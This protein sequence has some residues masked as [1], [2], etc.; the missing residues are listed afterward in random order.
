MFTVYKKLITPETSPVLGPAITPR[1]SPSLMPTDVNVNSPAATALNPAT[2]NLTAAMAME[3]FSLCNYCCSP[4]NKTK[5]D[6]SNVDA[7]LESL[8]HPHVIQDQIKPEFEFG[9]ATHYKYNATTP[10]LICEF[11]TGTPP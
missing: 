5:K 8:I 3:P 9:H 11:E 7:P 1:E 4:R 10:R 2:N 6:S